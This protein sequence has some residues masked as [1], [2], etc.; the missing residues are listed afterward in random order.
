MRFSGSKDLQSM[1][2]FVPVRL[3]RSAGRW[4]AFALSLVLCLLGV[5][6]IAGCGDVNLGELLGIGRSLP[7]APAL[8]IT[9]A[10][11]S[12]LGGARVTIVGTDAPVFDSGTEVL[13]G[14]LPTAG[15]EVVDAKTIRVTAP[16]QYAGQVDVVVQVTDGTTVESPAGFEYV[17]VQDGDAEIL[18]RIEMMFPGPPR[19]VSAVATSN[20]GVRVMFSEPVGAGATDPLN[21]EIVIPEGGILRLD[22]TKAPMLSD[23]GTVADLT[24]L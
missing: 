15:V 8:R 19:L 13:F 12:V 6:P 5:T 23:D 9:P 21:Y 1:R 7:E 17:A 2:L 18:N 20:I 11:D 14:E 3:Q 4:A 16:A 10:R 22:S 24:T